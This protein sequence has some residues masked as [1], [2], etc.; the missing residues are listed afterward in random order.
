M[1][2]LLYKFA[3]ACRHRRRK[4]LWAADLA[5]GRRG[6]DLAHRYLQELG[7]IVVARNYRPR[8]GG[9]ELDIIAWDGATLVFVEVKTRYSDEHSAPERAIDGFKRQQL[10]R[11]ARD[12]VRRAGLAWSSVRFD[13]VS[14]L[15]SERPQ[16]THY[17]DVFSLQAAL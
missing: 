12:Y 11:G 5:T 6:E 9:P 14:V 17:R 10:F 1:L 7:F 16:I 4:R 2:S 15:L 13:I 3:D 8:P